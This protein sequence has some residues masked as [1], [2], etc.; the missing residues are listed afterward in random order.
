MTHLTIDDTY[1]VIDEEQ[2]EA[3]ISDERVYAGFWMRFWAYLTDVLIVIS[4]N[5]VIL[6]PVTIFNDGL[7]LTV[8][9]WTVSG[10]L[11]AIVFY[12]YF[13]LMT[14]YFQQTIGK[15]LFHIE[16]VRLDGK[17]LQWTDVLF[18][19]VIGRF[20]HRAFFFCFIFYAVV[21]FTKR[22]QGIHDL[23]AETSVIHKD[24]QSR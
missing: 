14:K 15:I 24:R 7:P 4:V 8:S 5:G 2:T 19:E 21:G 20:I 10:I 12:I 3:K 18:R 11:G 13:A 1:D 22:K 17:S 9:Y 6:S 16:V 23:F